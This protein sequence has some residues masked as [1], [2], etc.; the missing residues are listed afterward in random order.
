MPNRVSLQNEHWQIESKHKLQG[1]IDI[2]QLSQFKREDKGREMFVYF[3]VNFFYSTKEHT[4]S[5]LKSPAIHAKP[6]GNEFSMLGEKNMMQL[7]YKNFKIITLKLLQII[8]EV[9]L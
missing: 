8:S 9:S 4:V 3:V 1:E 7:K 2:L 6:S 5:R